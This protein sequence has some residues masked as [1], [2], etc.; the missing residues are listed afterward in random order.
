MPRTPDW[1]VV[2]SGP[3]AQRPVVLSALE[4]AGLTLEPSGNSRG[5]HYGLPDDDPSVGWVAVRHEDVNDVVE[6]VARSGWQLR[7]HWPTP[8]CGACHGTGH[9]N[10]GTSGLGSCLHCGGKG[11]TNKPV[12]SPEEQMEATVRA[13]EARLAAL[14]G[15]S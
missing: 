10:H 8:D 3:L 7:L 4:R 5:Y 12:P 6:H 13:L 15:K 14:E 9:V 11:A 1:T 2:L